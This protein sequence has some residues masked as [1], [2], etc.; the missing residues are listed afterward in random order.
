VVVASVEVP[1]VV[2]TASSD[3]TI[4]GASMMTVLVPVEV[5][6]SWSVTT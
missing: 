5:K 3:G 2:E 6:P 1:D 4:D